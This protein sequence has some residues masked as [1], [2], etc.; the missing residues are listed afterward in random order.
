MNGSSISA[1]RKIDPADVAF[2][3]VARMSH[4]QRRK[5]QDKQKEIRDCVTC[6]LPITRPF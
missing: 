1:R 2:N 6:E 5:A 4:R 3:E